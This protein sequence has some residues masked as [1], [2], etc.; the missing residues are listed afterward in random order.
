M[1]SPLLQKDTQYTIDD[2]ISW[3]DEVRYE[4]IN[5]VAYALSSPNHKH[6]RI[7]RRLST[8]LDTFLKGKPCEL[9]FAPSD[10]KLDEH[11]VIQPDLFVVCDK[12]KLD[13]QFTN[14]A[15]DFV[16]EILSPE[17]ARK[18]LLVKHNKYLEAK[19]REYWIIDPEGETIDVFHLDNENFVNTEHKRKEK[20]AVKVL[21][22]C[23]IDMSEIFVEL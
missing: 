8:V 11:T 15:P 16:I 7:T 10:V 12:T 22:D 5:G 17:T 14:G 21:F 2:Y 20:V 18:D 4:L 13:G 19:V 9:F 23:V 6:Q 1:S 3:D